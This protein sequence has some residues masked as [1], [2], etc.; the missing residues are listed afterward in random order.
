LTEAGKLDIIS[1]KKEMQ[2]MTGKW[3]P[4]SIN[5][6][7]KITKHWLAGFIFFYGEAVDIYIWKKKTQALDG[8]GCFYILISKSKLYKTG[9]SVQ[10]QFSIAQHRRDAE[11]ISKLKDFFKCG[12]IKYGKKQPVAIFTVTKISDIK[13]I[14]IPLLKV[15]SV[16]APLPDR[17]SNS[18]RAELENPLR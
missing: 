15:L 6:Q 13:N 12:F 11:L 7:I 10:L 14:I 17:G 9:A 4:S 16:I 1:Y 5:N 18:K 8:E 2:S 3:I